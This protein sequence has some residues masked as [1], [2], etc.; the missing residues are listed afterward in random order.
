MYGATQRVT[1]LHPQQHGRIGPQRFQAVIGAH[2]GREHVDDDIAIIHQH[3]P[4]PSHTFDMVRACIGLR[5]D[6]FVYAA[7]YCAKLTFVCT[8]AHHKIIGNAG[9][10]AQIEEQNIFGFFVG[11][12]GNCSAR[13][14]KGLRFIGGA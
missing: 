13:K 10:R 5:M 14:H 4:T 9:K 12:G 11:G 6:L 2:A 3:P 8:R 7:S 1:L